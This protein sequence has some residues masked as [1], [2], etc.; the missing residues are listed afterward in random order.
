MET[1]R[2]KSIGAQMHLASQ[3]LRRRMHHR[4]HQLGHQC[5]MEQLSI[6]KVFWIGFFR[7]RGSNLYFRWQHTK[8]CFKI[9]GKL[10]HM[11]KV[12]FAGQS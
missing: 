2:D 5:T 9:F 6:P 3:A 1:P 8:L 12:I 10:T 11:P 4:I 7:R